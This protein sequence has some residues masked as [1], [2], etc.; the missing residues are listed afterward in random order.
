MPV[1]L[2]NF[3]VFPRYYFPMHPG[4]APECVENQSLGYINTCK[5]N[6]LMNAL[7]RWGQLAQSKRPSRKLFQMKVAAGKL[8]AENGPRSEIAVAE[9]GTICAITAHFLC[10]LTT[11][12]VIQCP[13]RLGF[14]GLGTLMT[15]CV[16]YKIWGCQV[17]ALA[18]C[19]I[20]T[21]EVYYGSI[22]KRPVSGMRNEKVVTSAGG[23]VRR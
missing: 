10:C 8:P 3:Q 2:R 9:T 11:T 22:E 18:Q 21:Q 23:R 17:F 5:L 6:V 14:T 16:K 19:T 1:P 7:G 4:C 13:D 12:A 20:S 15:E